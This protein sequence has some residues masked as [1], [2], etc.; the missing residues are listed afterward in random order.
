MTEV[1]EQLWSVWSVSFRRIERLA[2]ICQGVF[3]SNAVMTYLSQWM[4][5]ACSAIYF[6][7]YII[8]KGSITPVFYNLLLYSFFLTL[9]K[10]T[11]RNV[12][13][14]VVRVIFTWSADSWA[15]TWSALKRWANVLC[16]CT[17]SCPV[18]G[19]LCR[20]KSN[21]ILHKKCRLRCIFLVMSILTHNTNIQVFPLFLG[22]KG[23]C[24]LC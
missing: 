7:F 16:K 3:L 24:S 1:P 13:S 14:F 10:Q 8:F 15:C 22:K 6:T 17:W 21:W 18:F 5:V 9:V 23:L 4:N 2:L 19:L 20:N 12:D 11:H